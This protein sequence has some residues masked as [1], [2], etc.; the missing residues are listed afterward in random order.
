MNRLELGKRIGCVRRENGLTADRL[1]EI[2]GVQPITI[3]QIEGGSRLPSLTLFVNICNALRASPN[4]FLSGSLKEND[5]DTLD[6][7]TKQLGELTP[8]QMDKVKS[9]ITAVIENIQ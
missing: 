3:R 9:I 5:Q 7:L 8:K 1:S 2:C 6:G 4:Y